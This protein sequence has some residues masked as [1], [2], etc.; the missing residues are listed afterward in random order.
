M[1]HQISYWWIMKLW[2]KVSSR[3]KNYIQFLSGEVV[4]QSV[5]DWAEELRVLASSLDCTPKSWWQDKVTVRTLPRYLTPKCKCFSLYHR[6]LN[7]LAFCLFKVLICSSKEK[8]CVKPEFYINIKVNLFHSNVLLSYF[9]PPDGTKY[10]LAT[11]VPSLVVIIYNFLLQLCLFAHFRSINYFLGSLIYLQTLVPDLEEAVP[12]PCCHCHAIIGHTQAA[13]SVVV[14]CKDSCRDT[15][16]WDVAK[17]LLC[18]MA[19]QCCS[20]RSVW[21]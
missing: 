7:A 12:R 15:R 14:T 3:C 2:N 11:M 9:R 17:E 16:G 5:R 19:V 18:Q 4:A 8:Q 10:W 13:H 21:Y 1:Q 20:W 6:S